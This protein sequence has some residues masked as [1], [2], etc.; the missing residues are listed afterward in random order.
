[1][2]S[3]ARTGGAGGT[4]WMIKKFKTDSFKNQQSEFIN[5]QLPLF[6]ALQN[7]MTIFERP[8]FRNQ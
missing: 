8:Q 7:R 5:R 4:R 2:N 6:Q 3:P 1:M